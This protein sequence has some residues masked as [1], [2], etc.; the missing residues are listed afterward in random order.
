MPV[1]AWASHAGPGQEGLQLDRVDRS[2]AEACAAATGEDWYA[3]V[4]NYEAALKELPTEQ[5]AEARKVRLALAQ[6]RM[7][8]EQLVDARKELAG[9]VDELS[10]DPDADPA[11]LEEARQSYASAQYYI[12][13]LMRLEGYPREEWEPEIEIARQTY[14]LLAEQADAAGDTDLARQRREDLESAVKLAR[15]D[16]QE[17]QGLPLP[18]Q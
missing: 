5:V 10:S 8:S 15:L 18:S 9:L 16:L 4:A 7:L 6:A 3:A 12:T 13:W 11:V 1:G 17:L 2:L 14:R